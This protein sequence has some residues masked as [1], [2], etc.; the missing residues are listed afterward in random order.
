MTDTLDMFDDEKNRESGIKSRLTKSKSPGN[1]YL[2]KRVST[3]LIMSRLV[4]DNS[5]ARPVT[6]LR[7]QLHK[8]RQAQGGVVKKTAS[9]PLPD[10]DDDDRESLEKAEVYTSSE[11]EDEDLPP[12]S[13]ARRVGIQSTR[14]THATSGNRIVQKTGKTSVSLRSIQVSTS[15]GKGLTISRDLASGKATIR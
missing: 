13:T 11:T 9:E 6:D 2:G 12:R 3:C 5:A 8:K 1:N 15:P 4:S 7:V 10:F 14:R